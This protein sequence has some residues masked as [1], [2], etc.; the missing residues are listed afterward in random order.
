MRI[1][2]VLMISTVL[3][4]AWVTP[5]FAWK[6]GPTGGV[7]TIAEVNEK[8]EAGDLVMVQGRISDVDLG[9]GSRPIV[10]L[11]DETGSVLVRVSEYLMR[12]L[13]EGRTPQIGA[14]VRVGGKWTHAYLDQDIWGIH[15]QTAERVEE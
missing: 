6:D 14:H 9:S 13:N 15:A 1:H 12:H 4:I 2:T 8:A 3:L 7:L 10:T 11:R 5:T